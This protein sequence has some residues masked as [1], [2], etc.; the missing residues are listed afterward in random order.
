MSRPLSQ[1]YSRHVDASRLPH[2]TPPTEECTI[3]L[4]IVCALAVPT[5]VFTHYISLVYKHLEAA[6]P[7][8]EAEAAAAAAAALA[9]TTTAEAAATTSKV[10]A[11]VARRAAAL[12]VIE[13][14]RS[15]GT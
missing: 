6:A 9:A 1:R 5:R 10:R 14:A 11:V 15:A 3:W 2:S 13:R 8:A 4:P 7:A 12:L